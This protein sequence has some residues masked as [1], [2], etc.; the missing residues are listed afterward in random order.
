[1]P[2]TA[3]AILCLF[4]TLPALPADPSAPWIATWAASPQDPG[5]LANPKSPLLNIENQTVRER[6]RVSIGGP[7]I[8]IRLSNEY[9]STP[10]LIGGVTVA[11]P[12]G[13][14]GVVPS[15]LQPVTFSRRTSVTIPAGAPV[16]SD[17][18]PFPLAAGAEIS[19][20]FLNSHS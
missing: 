16:L 5:P 6:V 9:G 18:L 20:R 4:L 1:M 7:Q 10:L 2:R 3:S 13:A 8:R 14:A 19:I 15:T 12:D 11:S 17:P